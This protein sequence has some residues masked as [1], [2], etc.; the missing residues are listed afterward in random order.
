MP[1]I[2]IVYHST[3]GNTARLAEAIAEGARAVPFTEVDVRRLEPLRPGGDERDASP[4]APGWRH[5]VLESVERLADYDGLV[6]GTPTRHGGM[7]A[8]LKAMFDQTGEWWRDG[9]LTDRV[10]SAF[11]TS[12]TLHGGHETTL[13]SIMTAMANLGMILVPPGFTDPVM[14]RGGSPFGATATTASEI[15]EDDLAAGRH[16]GRRVAT[17][18]EWVRH[19]KGHAAQGGGGHSHHHDHHQHH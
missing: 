3:T 4:G 18:A 13:W 16:Q 1:K 11:T 8:E 5:R 6:L 12:G 17:V 9:R 15:N 10:G 7:S 2:L 14:Q 19:A